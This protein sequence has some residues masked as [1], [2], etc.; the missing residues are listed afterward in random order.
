[1]SLYMNAYDLIFVCEKLE[2]NIKL[3][4]EIFTLGMTPFDYKNDR[5]FYLNCLNDQ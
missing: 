5:I 1:M 3:T 2:V 4:V